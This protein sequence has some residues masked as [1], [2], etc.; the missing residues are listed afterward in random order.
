MIKQRERRNR[1]T[2]L[3][4]SGLQCTLVGRSVRDMLDLFLVYH[5][6]GLVLWR[7][8]LEP[9]TGHPVSELIRTVLLEER[10]ELT[11]FNSGKY[12]LRWCFDNELDL[13]FVVRF[14][15]MPRSS[16]GRG[17]GVS[18]VALAFVRSGAL[19]LTTVAFA[20]LRPYPPHPTPVPPLPPNPLQGGAQ[21]P[22]P[23]QLSG[24][25]AQQRQE[26]LCLD[27]L[28]GS[29]SRAGGGVA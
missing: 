21:S 25:A 2:K 5:R 17:R 22:H 8:E 27:V 23:G 6:G 16:E 14:V 28:S 7:R 20:H 19:T 9:L 24:H 26:A 18:S 11:S 15:R 10:A 29:S 13:V 1:Q 12:T 3:D 4:L